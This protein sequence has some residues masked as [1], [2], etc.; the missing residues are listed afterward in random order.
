MKTQR[1]VQR[2]KDTGSFMLVI[3]MVVCLLSVFPYQPV[4]AQEDAGADTEVGSGEDDSNEEVVEDNMGGAS[5]FTIETAIGTQSVIDKK[6]PVYL[7][8]KPKINSSKAQLEWN[9]PRGL[10]ALSSTDV[11]FEMEEDVG[12]TFVLYV[13]PQSAGHYKIVINVTAWRFD[14]NYVDS[15][16]IEIDID[17]S[18]LIT[19]QTAEYKRNNIFLTAGIVLAGGGVIVGGYFLINLLRKRFRKWMSED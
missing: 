18:L 14:T 3:W 4:F 5:F 16:E 17:S 19:P 1:K 11:W 7:Y 9:V 15:D 12:R 10:E 6:I 13:S 2:K 8:L